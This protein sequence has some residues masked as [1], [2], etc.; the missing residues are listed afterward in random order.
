MARPLDVVSVEAIGQGEFDA[1]TSLAITNDLTQPSE[2]A[3][4]VG[5]D[6]TWDE[7]EDFVALGKQYQVKVNGRIVLTGRLE[8]NNVKGDVTGGA[9]IR[10]TA[11]TK[12]AD[13]NFCSGNPN[14]KVKDITLADWLVKLY[15]PLGYT[16]SDF[17]FKGNAA[18]DLIT[19]KPSKST[20][21]PLTPPDKVQEQQARVQLP[22]TIF[23]AADRHLRRFGMMHWDSPDG[24]IV[25]SAPDDEQ[26]SIYDFRHFRGDSASINNVLDIER[27]KDF[28]GIPNIVQVNGTRYD[29]DGFPIGKTQG[30]A[31]DLDVTAAG[32]TRPILI[33]G[34][35]MGTDALAQAAAHR[36]LSARSQRKDALDI[37]AD[38]LSYWDGRTLINFA[39]DTVGDVATDIAGGALGPYYLTRVCLE[40]RPG[41]GTDGG[42]TSRIT[43]LK[44]GV[45]R[46]S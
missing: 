34:Q 38:G 4:E 25:V 24:K 9:A 22:E 42:D 21:E 28:S 20:K 1:F 8:L 6:G 27:A 31:V 3:F 29:S 5:D 16:A 18:R 45:W 36:E 46:L 26:P 17:V 32:F 41:E 23:Q 13:A 35:Q 14:L 2:A 40:R 44:Q 12:L 11:R 19:G 37:S 15:A 43:L 10:M 33:P 7:L 39:P 30:N